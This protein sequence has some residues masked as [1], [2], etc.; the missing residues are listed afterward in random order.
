MFQR[1]MKIPCSPSKLA[2]YQD[3]DLRV[4]RYTTH[5]CRKTCRH[6][7]KKSGRCPAWWLLLTGRLT[8]GFF[9][10][11]PWFIYIFFLLMNI[12]GFFRKKK[13]LRNF[14]NKLIKENDLEFS[15]S[16]DV[17]EACSRWHH[18]HHVIWGR[19]ALDRRAASLSVPCSSRGLE[20]GFWP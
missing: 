8:W 18:H 12:H 6:T 4:Y 19:S 9:Y 1:S 13:N 5:T 3:S 14:P 20:T 17:M 16:G 10:T 7:Q 15:C 2:I 11:C